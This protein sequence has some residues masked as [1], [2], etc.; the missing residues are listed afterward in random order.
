[1]N[2]VLF[3]AYR[4]TSDEQGRWSPVGQL[5]HTSN[6]YRFVYTKGAQTLA[7]FKPF[8]GMERLNQVYQSDELFP[9]FKNRLLTKSRP[10]YDAYLT[11]GGFD[12][13]NP[14][15]PIALL[16][17]TEGLRQ[18]D[19]LEVFPCPRPDSSG[20]YLTKF[21]L[22]GIR[23]THP[24]ARERILRLDPGE[25][26]GLLLDISNTNDPN[27][28]AVR[29]CDIGDRL[30]LGY[31]PRYL[32]KEVWE[33]IKGCGTGNIELTV[34]RV[35]QEAPMQHRLLCRMTACWPDGFRPCQSEE[36]QPI[37]SSPLSVH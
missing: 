25:S 15:D 1:M 20:C 26:L 5:E 3:I 6:G 8:P 22:H 34:E 13:G 29:T 19:S 27:A 16:G 28:V 23:W 7:G 30:L 18:T 14:P 4:G 11:W 24:A 33:L 32:A 31:V 21:F 12:P 36:F 37:V 10:E 9:L 2:Q 17:V 35:N